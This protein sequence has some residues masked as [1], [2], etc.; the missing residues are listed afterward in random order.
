MDMIPDS[1]QNNKTIARAVMCKRYNTNKYSKNIVNV[2][3]TANSNS[4]SNNNIYVVKDPRTM[5]QN[6]TTSY[7]NLDHPRNN[8]TT[9]MNNNVAL[10]IFHQNILLGLHNKID[11]PLTC[12][13]TEF[14]HLLCLTEHH[15][16]DYEIT[17][18]YIEGHNLATKYCRKNRKQGGVSIYIRET[19]SYTN[20][21]L[22]K[23][24]N[25]QDLEVCVVKLQ[26][27]F[28]K[29]Y[30]L[31]VYRPPTGNISYFL[32]ALESILNQLY[33]NSTI[34][35][36]CGDININYLDNTKNKQQLDAL[37]ASYGLHSIV[38][39]PTRIK[40]YSSTAIDNFIKKYKNSNFTTGPQLNGLSDH[41][42]QILILNNLE[43]QNSRVGYYTKR[44]I[45]EI[46]MLEFKLNLSYVS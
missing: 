6:I 15:L 41:D 32:S 43:I 5:K 4:D 35:I 16:R 18:T 22:A 19:L 46:T 14:P 27:S 17:N 1:A 30:V 28:Y 9:K 2:A 37:L 21:E 12:W 26:S 45:N 34:I 25:D 23:F 36:T 24:C 3:L 8:S 38:D 11:E 44:L 13:A 31:C 29:I 33:T 20:I 39:F 7:K 42:A 40:N 10:T